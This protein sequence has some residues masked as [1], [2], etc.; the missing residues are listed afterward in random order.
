M[1]TNRESFPPRMFIVYGTGS[2]TSPHESGHC[3]PGSVTPTGCLKYRGYFEVSCT[4][5]TWREG[6]WEGKSKMLII[7]VV[8]AS[9]IVLSTAH[10]SSDTNGATNVCDETFNAVPQSCLNAYGALRI[11]NANNTQRMMVCNANETCYS[12]LQS[13]VGNCTGSNIVRN[14]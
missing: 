13:V 1:L 8:I 2:M 3:D 7:A 9:S 11:G 14:Y 6:T 10:D 5:C 4:M 12:H